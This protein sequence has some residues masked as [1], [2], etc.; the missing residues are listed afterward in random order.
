MRK[1]VMKIDLS[2]G[3]SQELVN[4][5]LNFFIDGPNH[6]EGKPSVIASYIVQCDV[7]AFVVFH[8][9]PL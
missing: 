3:S 4:L 2:K 1:S 8:S 7:E 9:Q 6:N 5:Y